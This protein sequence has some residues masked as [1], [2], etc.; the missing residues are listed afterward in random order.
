MGKKIVLIDGNSLVYRAFFALPTSLT[1][2]SGQV[3]NAVY[4]FT[5]ML[6]KLLK[7]EK[8]DVL[9]VAFDKGRSFRREHF[10]EYKAHRPE[11]PSE[12][13]GQFSLVREV[14]RVLNIPTV[15]LAGYEADD[16]LA[17]LAKRAGGKDRD[18]IVVTGDRDAFQMVGDGIRI[19]TTRKGITDIVMYDR[20]G[21]I[22]RY[23]VPPELVV[24]FLA[25]KGDPSDNIPGVPGIGEKTAAKLIQEFGPVES[26]YE[27]LDKIGS[28]R[29][30]KMLEEHAAEARLSKQL[31]MLET[32]L[33]LDIDLE[34][35]EVGAWDE[36]EVRSVF[37]TL[38]FNTLLER[39]F[40]PAPVAEEERP[41][42]VA[43]TVEITA[44]RIK[45]LVEK[46]KQADRYAVHAATEGASIDRRLTALAFALSGESVYHVVV[47]G[48]REAKK[49]L[50]AALK[51][52]LE[53]ERPR[54]VVHDVKCLI[55]AL[56]NEGIRCAGVRFDTLLAAYLDFPERSSYSLE[57]IYN[58][59]LKKKL[60]EELFGTG[61][62]TRAAAVL[63]LETRLKGLL[64]EQEMYALLVDLELPLAFVLAKM[65]RA[66]VGIDV[67]HFERLSKEMELQL[68][69]IERQIFTLAGEEFNIA[70][71]QQLGKILFE[72]LGLPSDRK[73]KTGYSTDIRVLSKLLNAHPIIELVIEYR[74][75]AK[76]KSTYVDALPK[77]VNPETGRLHTTFNQTGTST[78]RLSSHDPNLQ[79]IPI[80]TEL[81]MR[82][83]EGFVPARAGDR[84]VASDYSQIELRL[85]A[86]LSGDSLLIDAFHQG[87]DIHSATAQQIFG[88][89]PEQVTGQMRRIAKMINFGVLY[90]MSAF[91]LADRLNIS[92]RDAKEYIDRYFGRYPGVR[93]FVT[94]TISGATKSGY[95][96]T[97]LGRRRPVP[98]LVSSDRRLKG[99]GERLAVNAPLQGSAADI[100]KVAMIR[101]DRTLAEKGYRA[102][103]VLQVHDELI[104]EVPSDEVDTVKAA[105]REVMETAY[106]LSVPLDV[107]VSDGANWKD[108]K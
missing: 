31:A 26:I 98:E 11:T 13:P 61:L 84:L 37:T 14:L 21:V 51:E 95:T 57:E 53:D 68:E 15:E 23:G 6:L 107:E 32:D 28:E 74:E 56:E 71:S 85:L 38:E 46:L 80:R 5:S 87:V 78:G 29:L 41:V 50:F 2:A 102:V 75:I 108:A 52:E 96:T 79:N 34:E 83:R 9:V 47:P 48:A 22:D 49:R 7:D 104:L 27:N 72:K 100:I 12:L 89:L 88:A 92:Q 35:C 18:V 54:K 67:L 19:M 64:E 36:Q 42:E 94:R 44:D 25:L 8:P 86:H 10:S 58:F 91:G 93:E 1:T 60:P 33:P 20:Q 103:M 70:S 45:E 90:G 69:Q 63:E 3:T 16:I 4:G 99:L 43:E 81:G 17:T 97:V 66:G 101:L 106:T 59:Y 40:G 62:G 73:T 39:F 105:V 82:I 65:E 55:P 30:R 76:L 24:D 77:L